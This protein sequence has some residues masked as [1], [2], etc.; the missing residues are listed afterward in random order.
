MKLSPCAGPLLAVVLT[1]CS[2][3]PSASGIP[4]LAASAQPTTSAPAPAPVV[5]PDADGVGLIHMYPVQRVYSLFD[6]IATEGTIELRLGIDPGGGEVGTFRYAPLVDGVPALD[7]ETDPLQRANT[8]SYGAMRLVGKRPDLL[9]HTVTGFRSAGDDGYRMLGADNRWGG[10]DGYGEPGMGIGILPWSLDRW[11]E[12]RGLRPNED[13]MTA[14][15]A[16]LPRMRVLRGKDKQAPSIPKA[17]SARLA[18]AGFAL[19]TFTAFRSGEVLCA[20]KLLAAKGFGT[21]V[22]TDDLK[23]PRYFVTEGPGITR[24]SEIGILGGDSLAAV[25][26]QVDSQVMKLEGDAWVVESTVGRDDLPDV[27]FG[28]PMVRQ[29]AAGGF[30]RLAGGAPWRP[31]EVLGK[32]DEVYQHFA[33]DASGVVYKL[34]D[35]LLLSNRRPAVQLPDVTEEELVK[36]RKASILRGGSDDVTGAPPS[37][38]GGRCRMHYLLLD[39]APEK[40]ADATDYARFRAALAGHPEVAKARLIVSREKGHQFFGALVADYETASKLRALVTAGVKGASPD[41]LCAEPNV[42]REIKIDPAT[43]NVVK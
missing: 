5:V 35:D 8:S 31:I 38:R 30:A 3:T 4:P 16:Q 6:M 20:G 36:A 34:E 32:P 2:S 1:A 9:L 15:D 21:L 41:V 19:D 7:K 29:T 17:L 40:T 12:W 13:D 33:I 18:K 43:G 42:V 27:W 11:L 37:S 39:D 28:A 10:F 25:R 24:S 14:P 23:A 22:W 26:V